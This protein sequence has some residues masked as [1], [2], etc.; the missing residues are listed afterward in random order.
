MMIVPVH[1]AGVATVIGRAEALIVGQFSIR[2]PE[3]KGGEIV[4]HKQLPVFG[5]YLE[6]KDG[7]FRDSFGSAQPRRTLQKL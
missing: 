1:S 6:R 5:S 3:Q 2:D 7:A 4:V